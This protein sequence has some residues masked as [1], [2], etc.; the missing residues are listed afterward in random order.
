MQGNFLILTALI[1]GFIHTLFG[2]DHYLPFIVMSKARQWNMVKT[3]AVTFFCG[4]VHVLSSIFLGYVGISFGIKLLH[5]ENLEAVRGEFAAWLMFIAGFTYFVWGIHYA[6]KKG[7]DYQQT[8]SKPKDFVAWILFIIF[9]LGPCEPLIPLLMY[10]AAQVNKFLL[11]LVAAVFS[12]TTIM[13]MLFIVVLG[14][15]GFAKVR[16]PGV[17]RYAHAVAGLVMFLCG[18]AILFLGL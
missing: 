18:G 3:L 5:L 17:R 4:L 12:L 15:Y 9:V 8:H 1:M 10:P 14:S 11:A 7:K 13:T 16:F 2:P 6:F